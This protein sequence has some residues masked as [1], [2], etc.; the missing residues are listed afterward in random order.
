MEHC[1]VWASLRS[2][3]SR[4]LKKQYIF[5]P[6]IELR[7]KRSQQ[8][9][10]LIYHFVYFVSVTAKISSVFT[11]AQI[12]IDQK[13]EQW[14]KHITLKRKKNN[15]VRLFKITSKCV[16]PW[17][18]RIEESIDTTALVSSICGAQVLGFI[19]CLLNA[20]VPLSMLPNN[21]SS[22]VTYPERVSVNVN[23]N[24]RS[25]TEHLSGQRR[26]RKAINTVLQHQCGVVLIKT[27]AELGG[28]TSSLA[29]AA[30]NCRQPSEEELCSWFQLV[31]CI[32]IFSA[33]QSESA[34]WMKNKRHTGFV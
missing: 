11:E 3:S 20:R 28:A 33:N 24:F 34:L 12:L 1:R 8:L 5:E 19:H 32:L 4:K 17:K 7:F 26:L 30:N 27:K 14:H 15:F 9:T 18:S 10:G 16:L 2:R 31:H 23:N 29:A 22:E 13:K 25:D 21:S 6:S